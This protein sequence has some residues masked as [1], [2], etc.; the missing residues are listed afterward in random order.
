MHFEDKI[1]YIRTKVEYMYKEN[2]KKITIKNK[3]NIYIINLRRKKTEKNNIYFGVND[4]T[5]HDKSILM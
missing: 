5:L 4:Y 1:L 3:N 2:T